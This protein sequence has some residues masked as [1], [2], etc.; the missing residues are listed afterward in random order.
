MRT[1]K[2]KQGWTIGAL[3]VIVTAGLLFTQTGS[4]QAQ[5]RKAGDFAPGR[6][7]VGWKPGISAAAKSKSL[8]DLGIET[9]EVG[10][11]PEIS[12]SVVQVP[13]GKESEAMGQLRE[14]DGV[15]YVELDFIA[16]S[17][18]A[19][20]P[21]PDDEYHKLQWAPDRMGWSSAWRF[22][23]RTPVPIAII[24]D[25]YDWGHPDQPTNIIVGPTFEGGG[26]CGHGT[27]VIGVVA[28]PA[29]GVGIVGSCPWCQ[30]I[31]IDAAYESGGRCYMHTSDAA[32]AIC[33]A[34]DAGAKVIVMSY[35]GS[36]ASSAEE[37]AVN[38]AVTRGSVVVTC[39]GNHAAEQVRYPCGYANAI[40]ASATNLSDQLA[41]FSSWGKVD[42]AAPGD[43][44]LTTQVGGGWEYGWGTS[45]AAPYVGAAAA[46]LW[47]E[48]PD[49]SRSQVLDRLATH[50]DDL[51]TPGKD[52]TFGW[53]IPIM[54]RSLG[55]E[56]TGT[57]E[58]T[59]TDSTSVALANFPVIANRW[60]TVTDGSGQYSLTIP[61]GTWPVTVPGKFDCPNLV[62][63]ERFTC[64]ATIDQASSVILNPVLTRIPLDQCHN[65]YS[66][67][68]LKNQEP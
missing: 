60:S 26:M 41:D 16:E 14:S 50:V 33:W 5:E 9:R 35:S 18:D 67:I 46:L 45:Y 64:Q 44:I 28:A 68:T 13:E 10:A 12:V 54:D 37:R 53:G 2:Q 52:N 62:R 49:L 20:Y 57:L 65:I 25:G 30:I 34:A 27:S 56:L 58:G 6:V 39:A 21:L 31:V 38:Y 32:A 22:T 40:C 15:A 36:R 23:L 55:F 63:W 19:P 1:E 3:F 24:D 17:D 29:N 66:P 42:F 7:I 61:T 59:V 11:I 47:S 51:G 43:G 4:T 48:Y 8:L